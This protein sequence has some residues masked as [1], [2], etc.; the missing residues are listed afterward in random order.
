MSE[1]IMAPVALLDELRPAQERIDRMRG[2]TEAALFG[3][4][5]ALGLPGE[6]VFDGDG[7]VEPDNGEDQKNL[8][9]S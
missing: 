3:A 5:L 1:R 8:P 6:R 9:E 2:E 7:W 4:R